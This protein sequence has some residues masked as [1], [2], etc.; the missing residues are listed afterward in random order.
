M[1]NLD[2]NHRWKLFLFRM[3]NFWLRFGVLTMFI[4]TNH[5]YGQ[6]CSTNNYITRYNTVSYLEF[7][8]SREPAAKVIS[9]VMYRSANVTYH[10][11]SPNC[12][13]RSNVI[14]KHGSMK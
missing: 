11:I 10:S 4:L 14:I 8:T 13:E 12:E 2:L 3:V 9:I 6:I 1:H 7:F 5:I